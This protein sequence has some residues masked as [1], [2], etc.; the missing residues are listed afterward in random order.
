MT[1][2]EL[3][4][5][6]PFVGWRYNPGPVVDLIMEAEHISALYDI[7][8]GTTKYVSWETYYGVGAVAVEALKANLGA[9][10]M[11]QGSD[12]KKRVESLL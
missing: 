6:P 8:G 2:L 11:Q 5:H 3:H 4:N 12:L 10:F 7:G 1:Y 9:K